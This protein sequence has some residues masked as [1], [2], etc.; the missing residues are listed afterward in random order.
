MVKGKRKVII[1][2]SCLL[3]AGAMLVTYSLTFRRVE[4]DVEMAVKPGT[5]NCPYALKDKL[6]QYERDIKAQTEYSNNLETLNET[7]M[8]SCLNECVRN[9]SAI[10]EQTDIANKCAMECLTET[11]NLQRALETGA[12]RREFQ[13]LLDSKCK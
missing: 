10:G 6:N 5:Y 2:I 7:K 11:G 13:S 3:F 12:L 1:L 9:N 8:N 4:Y